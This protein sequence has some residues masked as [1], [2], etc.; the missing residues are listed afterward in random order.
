MFSTPIHI[1]HADR[2]ITY[3]DKILM[4]G[5]CFTENISQKLREAYFQVSVNPT[6]ILYNPLSIAQSIRWILSEDDSL[7]IQ[8]NGLWHSFLHHGDFSCADKEEFLKKIA[9]SRTLGRKA[10]EE[11]TVIIITFG[12]AWVYE[13]DGLVV[14][15]CHKLP[16]NAFN[17]RRLSVEEIINAWKEILALPIM[18]GK[19]IIFTVS[20]IRHLKDGLHENQISKATL[21]LACEGLTDSKIQSSCGLFKNSTCYFPSYEIMMD[22]LRDYRFYADDML[23]PSALAIDYIWQRFSETYFS[24]NTLREMQPLQQ[25]YRDRE[26]RPL[27]PDSHEYR[28]FAENLAEK[29]RELLQKYPWINS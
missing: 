4:L 8:N 2:E 22:E 7:I 15:N 3:Q 6:G 19:H 20:P 28:L 18:Q 14:A 27:H 9:K 21:L 23:H 10:L 16:A 13:K 11:A 26:H 24:Q 29:T 17:R 5:S 12:S 1:T 25:L